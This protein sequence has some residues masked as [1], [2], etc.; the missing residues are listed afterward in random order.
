M[1]SSFIPP[2][3]HPIRLVMAGLCPAAILV[4]AA[5]PFQAQAQV[6][7]HAAVR[8]GNGGVYG[9]T[10]AGRKGGVYGGA[11][12]GRKGGVYGG[13]IAGRN[14]GIYRGAVVVDR[15]RAGW[16]RGHPGFVGYRGPRAGYYFAPGHGYYAVPRANLHTTW[17]VGHTLP[18]TMQRYVVI[19]PLRFGLAPPPAGQRWFY[20]GP[21][22]V[23][24]R[25]SSGVIVRS[26]AGGW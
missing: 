24:A 17:V 7:G 13:A 18:V 8:T 15:S 10:V 22:F 1:K 3:I 16:W 14:G 23:L 11:V 6:V 25:S 21:N 2:L 12:A 26:V 20:A 4:A 9:G 19:N 5:M